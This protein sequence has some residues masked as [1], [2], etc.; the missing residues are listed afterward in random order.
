MSHLQLFVL[1]VK[2][3]TA[4][5]GELVLGAVGWEMIRGWVKVVDC[6]KVLRKKRVVHA[7]GAK[8]WVLMHCCVVDWSD[9]PKHCPHQSRS[10]LLTALYQLQLQA[11][12][13]RMP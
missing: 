8:G 7:R 5:H 10:D 12:G 3:I 11:G 6:P 4:G 2:P 13:R 9:V 1:L